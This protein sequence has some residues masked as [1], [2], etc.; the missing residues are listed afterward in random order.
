MEYEYMEEV[1][2]AIETDYAFEDLSL[3]LYN[4]EDN[5]NNCDA[6]SKQ[7]C[8]TQ[9][10]VLDKIDA[11]YEQILL[12]DDHCGE[13]GHLLEEEEWTKEA[14]K[15]PYGDTYVEEMIS[16]EYNCRKCGH[17]EGF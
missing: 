8:F 1:K 17:R 16:V 6:T 5:Y 7:A 2:E 14:E 12:N 15:V 13:C 3:D 9:E 11:C 4:R 10:E